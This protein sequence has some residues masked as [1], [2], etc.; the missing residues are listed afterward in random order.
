M[1]GGRLLTL[2]DV[3]DELRC[4]KA[5]V[6][7]RVRTGLLPVVVDGGLVRV[8]EE[9]LSRYVVERIERR[10]PDRSSSVPTGLSL[11]KGAKLWD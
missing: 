1:I 5:T 9:D 8:R 7:R 2:N 6:K 10:F 3:A 11:P 4:S